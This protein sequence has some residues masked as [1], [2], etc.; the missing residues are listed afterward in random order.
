[1]PKVKG[2]RWNPGNNHRSSTEGVA[3][4]SSEASSVT[5]THTQVHL[6][7]TENIGR[8]GEETRGKEGSSDR[9]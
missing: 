3:F 7:G 6:R 4:K 8:D 1:M 5:K 9:C 2:G